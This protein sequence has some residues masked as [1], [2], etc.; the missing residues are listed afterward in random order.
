M[1]CIRKETKKPKSG[2]ESQY[3]YGAENTGAELSLH[4]EE[5]AHW[6]VDNSKINIRVYKEL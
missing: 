3:E 6:T 2:Y 1:L 4:Q 5:G